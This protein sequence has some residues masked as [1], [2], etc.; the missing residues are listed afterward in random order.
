MNKIR[1]D[2]LNDYVFSDVPIAWIL[3]ANSYYEAG[4]ALLIGA[5]IKDQQANPVLPDGRR[6]FALDSVHTNRSLYKIACYLLSHAIEANLK[7]LYSLTKQ[8]GDKSVESFSHNITRLLKTLIE[9][10]VIDK[11]E[12]DNEIMELAELLLAWFG[13]YHKPLDNKKEKVIEKY[14]KEVPGEPSML[15]KKYEIN[16]N[17]YHKLAEVFQLLV[18]KIN[19]PN[20]H[21][22]DHFLFDPF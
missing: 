3:Q 14:Y 6:S 10:K 15:Q 1:K 22:I 11:N 5:R 19:R 20:E 13:R 4:E 16:L 12:V 18:K 2:I 7:A 17:T 8:E 21:S 9:K